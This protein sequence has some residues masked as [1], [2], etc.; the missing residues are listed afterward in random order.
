MNVKELGLDSCVS[1]QV[2]EEGCFEYV[3]NRWVG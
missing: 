3:I 1:G 2:P